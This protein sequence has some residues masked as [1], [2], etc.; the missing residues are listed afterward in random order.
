MNIGW[1]KFFQTSG[2]IGDLKIIKL[3]APRDMLVTGCIQRDFF[4]K[5]M[6]SVELKKYLNVHPFAQMRPLSITLSKPG[7]FT[8]MKRKISYANNRDKEELNLFKASLS[9]FAQAWKGDGFFRRH[10]PKLTSYIMGDRNVG[11]DKQISMQRDMVHH[12]L[13]HTIRFGKNKPSVA[14]EFMSPYVP[15]EELMGVIDEKYKVLF[16]NQRA[17]ERM[18]KI[19]NE[20]QGLVTLIDNR[21]YY[22]VKPIDKM[23][24]PKADIIQEEYSDYVEKLFDVCDEKIKY[25][26]Y[27]DIPA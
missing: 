8:R 27:N 25:D 26:S 23:I 20:S 24:R 19:R 4:D 2:T 9:G 5:V 17:L 15:Q 21:E 7:F 14:N 11:V 1:V 13:Y 10:L 6:N 22:K 18:M 12:P 3:M 16:K